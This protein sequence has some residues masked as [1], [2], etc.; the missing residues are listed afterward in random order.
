MS[1]IN[2][3]GKIMNLRNSSA[4]IVGAYIKNVT[5]DDTDG[6]NLFKLKDS[7]IFLKLCSLS[8]IHYLGQKAVQ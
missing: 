4:N 2:H 3:R 6:A 8:E 7:S 5:F 1:I